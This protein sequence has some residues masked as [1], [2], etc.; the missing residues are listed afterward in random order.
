MNVPNVDNANAQKG[1]L[2]CFSQ[3]MFGIEKDTVSSVN[4]WIIPI[5]PMLFELLPSSFDHDNDH[6]RSFHR[7]VPLVGGIT[8]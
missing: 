2:S 4:L 8:L 6:L 3:R 1:D 7:R 5:V